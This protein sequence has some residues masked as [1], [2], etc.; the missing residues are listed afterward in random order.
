MRGVFWW[1][2]F[3]SGKSWA[4][5]STRS[6]ALLGKS[7]I[8]QLI[9]KSLTFHWTHKIIAVFTTAHHWILTYTTWI[10]STSS[11]LV[12]IIN[13]RI[14]LPS[15]LR[16]SKKSLSFRVSDKN[17]ECISHLPHASYKTELELQTIYGNFLP[18][19]SHLQAKPQLASHPMLYRT[20]TAD[21][22]LLNK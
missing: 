6:R 14:T 12:S 20:Y 7:T 5:C 16:P 19:I 3:A 18:Y 2:S 21:K 13:F 15:A 11:H 22:V 4:N 8:T 9:K 1:H 10:Q 17:F